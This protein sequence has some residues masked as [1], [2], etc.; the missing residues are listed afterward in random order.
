LAV[1][2]SRSF[3]LIIETLARSVAPVHDTGEKF[4]KGVVLVST[5]L[6]HERG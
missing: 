5:C 2:R 4:D 3:E 6:S 1:Q